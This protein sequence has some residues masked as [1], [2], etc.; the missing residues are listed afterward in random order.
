MV[1]ANEKQIIKQAIKLFSEDKYELVKNC[2]RKSINQ[3]ADYQELARNLNMLEINLEEYI[4][5]LYNQMIE[6]KI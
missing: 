6:S 2:I 4:D 5:Y 1:V 3:K